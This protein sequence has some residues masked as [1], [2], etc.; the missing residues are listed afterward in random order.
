[1]EEKTMTE[2]ND[3]QPSTLI[4]VRCE[5]ATPST[6]WDISWRLARQRGLCPELT[7]FIFKLLHNI[8]PTGER[9]HRIKPSSSPLCVMCG[10]TQPQVC[11]SV[12]HAMV[13]CV[14]NLG[15]FYLLQNTIKQY[16]PSI[17]AQDILTLNY[18][19]SPHLELPLTWVTAATLSSLWTQRKE[20]VV[21]LARLRGELEEGCLLLQSSKFHNEYIMV[22]QIISDITQ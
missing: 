14:G 13:F 12:T 8:L 2:E 20:G 10:H 6:Q 16:I 22:S 11:E 17:K 1:M 9:I 18:D 21:S 5:L 4:P 7:S 15:I 19:V 3:D